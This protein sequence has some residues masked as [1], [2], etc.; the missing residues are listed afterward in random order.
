M[1]NSA[2]GDNDSRGRESEFEALSRELAEKELELATLENKLSAFEQRYARTIGILLAELDDLEKEIAKELYRLHPNEKYRQ[3]FQR[4]KRKA[5]TSQDAVDEKISQAEGEQFTPSDELKKLFRKV[6][7]TVHPDLATDEREQA[8]RN[9]L[10][11]R[12]NEAYRKGDMAALQQIL[13]EWECRDEKS[14]STEAQPSQS[15]Q[16]EQQLLQIRMRIKTIQMRIDGLKKSE[17]Y[18]L[19]IKVEQAA[20]QGRDLL[21]DMVMDLQYQIQSAKALLESFKQKGI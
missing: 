10:M 16:L 4:A 12:A 11:A 9:S 18:Q 17:L 21:G 13:D 5:K 19:L 6:A 3:G 14:I 1:P 15:D 7:K 20:L 2:L 8:Y